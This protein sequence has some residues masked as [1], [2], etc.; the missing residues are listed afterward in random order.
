MEITFADAIFA[1]AFVFGHSGR[2]GTV[3]SS[4]S[5]SPGIATPPLVPSKDMVTASGTRSIQPPIHS[6][7]GSRFS[8]LWGG[9]TRHSSGWMEEQW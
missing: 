9:L 8:P 3:R 5:L 7:S 2:F 4:T 1:S 6:P